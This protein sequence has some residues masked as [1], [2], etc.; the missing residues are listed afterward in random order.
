MSESIYGDY[1]QYLPLILQEVTDHIIEA[2]KQV[3]EETGF[4]LYEHFISRVKAADSM[5][6][7]CQRKDLP[8]TAHS[9][10][11]SIRDS[12]GIRIVCGFV[13]DIY[14]T[15]EIIRGIPGVSIYNEKDYIF[16]A[17]PNGYRSYHLILEMETD[18][19]DVEGN[20]RGKYFIEV[21]LRTIAQDS[22]ASLEH[23]MKYKHDIKN[24]EMITK[25][26]KRCA[27][28]LASCDLTMQTIRNLI[29]ESS[30]D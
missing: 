13:D 8:V 21:Q 18:Y 14:K 12:I 22:W 23:Q 9:A 19:P 1:G 11:K 25:E 5:A 20:A 6:E 24:P 3:K 16:N 27:D 29:Q 7:K 10:L 30:E 26:L 2:N 15:V 28:E 4:K 17:K